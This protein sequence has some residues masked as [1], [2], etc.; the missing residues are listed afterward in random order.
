MHA[1][2]WQHR[3][4]AQLLVPAHALRQS[5]LSE[6]QHPGVR[7]NGAKQVYWSLRAARRAR[8]R[9][10]PRSPQSRAG[11]RRAARRRARE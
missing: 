11:W 10:A 4:P 5:G 7:Q 9:G 8:A 1:G 2:A 6:A 3:G